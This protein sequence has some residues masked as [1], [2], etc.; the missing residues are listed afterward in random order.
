MGLSLALGSNPFF[1]TDSGSLSLLSTALDAVTR[2][3]HFSQQDLPV[4]RSAGSIG[5]ASTHERQRRASG[6]L[7]QHKGLS[8]SSLSTEMALHGG[9]GL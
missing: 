1:Y 2:R 8:Q 5:E 9:L 3:R 4:T 6:D 7:L